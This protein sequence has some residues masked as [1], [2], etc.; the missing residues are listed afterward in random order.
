MIKENKR[1]IFTRQSGIISLNKFDENFYQLINGIF[2]TQ[3]VQVIIYY[4]HI[5]RE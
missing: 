2:D 4:I 5:T 1:F 3:S